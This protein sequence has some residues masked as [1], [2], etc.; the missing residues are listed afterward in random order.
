[1]PRKFADDVRQRAVRLVEEHVEAHGC[2]VAKAC[3]AVASK[4]GVSHHTLRNWIR[5][6]QAQHQPTAEMSRE[7]L[8]REV[9]Q[10]RAELSQMERAN[11]ILKAA[12]AF[13]AAE[14]DRP[15]PR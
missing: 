15:G 9:K 12:S 13:F 5:Q 14:L 2:S 8:V 3:R 1:M 11:E 4:I 6:S 10:L 7:D